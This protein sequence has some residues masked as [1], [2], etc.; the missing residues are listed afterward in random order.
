ME[1][2]DHRGQE[3]QQKRIVMK[4]TAE[5][6]WADIALLSEAWGFPW[7]EDVALQVEAQILVR[8]S[9][10]QHLYIDRFKLIDCD[11][12]TLMFGPFNSGYTYQ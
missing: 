2:H 1:I 5:S 9:F 4:P 7:T 12:R 10:W 6:I 11:R 3:L 8:D